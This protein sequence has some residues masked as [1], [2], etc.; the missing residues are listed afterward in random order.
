VQED[1]EFK[2]GDWVVHHYHGVGKI[3]DI[4]KKGIDGDEKTYYK[5]VTP[6]MK[7]WIPVKDETSNNIEPIRSKSEFEE[8][9]QLLSQAPE[10]IAKHHKSRKKR[11]HDRWSE[12]SLSSRAKLLRDLNGR[13]LTSRLSFNE[14]EMM[15]K[16]KRYLINEW[17]IADDAMTRALAKKKIKKALKESINKI[18][19]TAEE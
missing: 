15:K 12:G 10:S 9:L 16:I 4:V 5:V 19:E 18:K 11:I 1:R 8:M 6:K 2:I 17:V 7:Y 14:K 3:K 13:Y